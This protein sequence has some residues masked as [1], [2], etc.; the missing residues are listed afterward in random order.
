M[1]QCFLK[2]GL[3]MV[4]AG[5]LACGC[6]K[7]DS[8]SV[9]KSAPARNS[10]ST[11]G[12]GELIAKLHWLGKRNLSSESSVT[13]LMAIWSSPESARLEAQTLDKL[14]SAPWRLFNPATALSNAPVAALRL[15]LDDLV[16]AE[17]YLEVRGA[18][19]Q[20]GQLVFAIR[21]DAERAAHWQTNLPPILKSLIPA[22]SPQLTR[23]GDWTLLAMTPSESGT[24]PSKLVVDF[25][26][27]IERDGHP[28]LDRATN[29]WFEA[30]ADAPKLSE[31]LRLGWKLPTTF[32]VI[33]LTVS[34]DG[35]NVRTRCEMNFP[36]P[37]P[38]LLSPWRVPLNLTTEP[39][40]GLTAMRSV[41]PLLE[42]L[43]ILSK[44]QAVHFPEQ[45]LVWL[46]A[47]PPLQIYFVLPTDNATNTFW[48]LAL[49]IKDWVNSHTD[50]RIYGS[51][52]M[53]TNLSELKW[54]GLSL[55][56]PFLK[57]VT[58]EAGQ[59]YVQGG[60]GIQ[61]P[62][63]TLLPRE[64]HD[65]IN[66]GTNLLFFDWEFARETLPQWRYLDDVSRMIFD[67]SHASRLRGSTNTFQWLHANVTNLSHSV[68]ELRQLSPQQ[69]VLTRRSTLGVN[70]LE[71]D[72]LLNW[73]EMPEF[74]RGM[75][76]LWRTNPAPFRP[77]RLTNTPPASAR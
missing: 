35:Q 61:P 59:H 33:D 26:A 41:A 42:R 31:A 29:H 25:K 73:I 69:L 14:S 34:G 9:D 36:E 5:V 56:A 20:P 67:G 32:P 44:D 16:Q 58:N 46:R 40:T 11:A 55:C 17:S 13:N 10:E 45:L 3:L 63:Q 51:I 62:N 23:V 18:A 30:R 49:P 77:V 2:L 22:A 39:L 66:Q 57:A 53:D 52:V 65:H 50:A 70:A 4:F 24:Q 15:V 74:P 8:S 60:F 76:T 54:N 43:G 37:L 48:K 19:N 64:L 6:S 28:W 27:R 7:T 38:P 71:L 47:G 12:A 21:L 75:S 68:T 72:I 1:N